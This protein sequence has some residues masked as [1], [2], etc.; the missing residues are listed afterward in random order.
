MDILFRL[1][2]CRSKNSMEHTHTIDGDWERAYYASAHGDIEKKSHTS[3]HLKR[4][5]EYMRGHL[6]RGDEVLEIG[7]GVAGF[8]KMMPN[9]VRYT[10]IESSDYALHEARKEYARMAHV[11]LMKGNAEELVFGDGTF[12][13]VFAKHVIE[14]LMYPQKALREM[15]RVLKNEGVLI[16]VAP[17]VEFPLAFPAAL[18]HTGIVFRV[19]FHVL[20]AYDY[21][22]RIAGVYRFRTIHN[23]YLQITGK[24]ERAD[25][26]LVY[27]VSSFEV[28]NF[29][30]R[31]GME[32]IFAS[33]MDFTI[34]KS[35]KNRVRRLFTMLPA[36]RYYG[37]EL[38]MIA[39]KS[40]DVSHR[41]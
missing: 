41:S 27:L 1:R 9:S 29:L 2:E 28:I 34:Q 22:S 20:R 5:L 26:D 35:F 21:L 7:C 4:L 25:D 33:S 8:A 17:N 15:V 36:L 39:K 6:T 37:V 38:C 40:G 3:A 11:R 23:N 18:R 12:D 16:L 32:I 19:G 10:G 13:L 14:H 30:K 24:Y 31:L